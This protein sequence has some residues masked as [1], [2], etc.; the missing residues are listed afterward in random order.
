MQDLLDST[1]LNKNLL[2]LRFE[3]DH[4]PDC[5]RIPNIP[6]EDNRIPKVRD[7]VAA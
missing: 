2:H 6:D 4:G 1:V 3:G 5:S 7:L